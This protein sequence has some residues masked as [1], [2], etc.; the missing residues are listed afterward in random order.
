MNKLDVYNL[1]NSLVEQNEQRVKE[2]YAE[3]SEYMQNTEVPQQAVISGYDLEMDK[4]NVE[5]IGMI[6]ACRV[7]Q[8]ALIE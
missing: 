8:D 1:V 4:L 5:M 6:K 3:K 7:I 2:L